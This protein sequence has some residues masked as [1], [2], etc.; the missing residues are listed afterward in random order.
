MSNFFSDV[1]NAVKKPVQGIAKPF[2]DIGRGRFDK[3]WGDIKHIP[4]SFEGGAQDTMHALGIGGWVGKHPLESAA[5]VVGSS[6]AA[7]YVAGAAGF[8]SA[9][10]AGGALGG[11]A[12]GGGALGGTAGTASAAGTTG[13]ALGSFG[14][15]FSATPTAASAG[16]SMF[17]IGSTASA[18][19][20]SSAGSAG[21]SAFDISANGANAF[22]SYMNPTT[23][24]TSA[25]D[26]AGGTTT[27]NAAS[28]SGF[29]YEKF[30]KLMEAMQGLKQK[31][32][33]GGGGA[34]SVPVGRG[35][36]NMNFDS[37]P[38]QNALLD[39]MYRE[40]YSDPLYKKL[41]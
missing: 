24:G 29:T 12:A 18:N 40:A 35:G 3:V 23:T 11:T 21:T 20:F 38:Y 7:P 25:F 10:S 6:F 37:K 2:E 5:A 39:N 17:D 1:F 33:G 9:G 4:G 32:E 22:S 30:S 15:G 14:G 19:S 8:G 31:D 16:T 13:G 36:G 27:S 26:I 34:P 28:G 41:Y